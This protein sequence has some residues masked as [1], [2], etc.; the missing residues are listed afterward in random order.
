MDEL[1]GILLAV[2]LYLIIAFSE[3]PLL[4]RLK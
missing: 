2:V 3:W 1:L 4:T